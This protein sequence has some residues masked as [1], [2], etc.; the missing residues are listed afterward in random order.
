MNPLRSSPIL[1]SVLLM[2]ISACTQPG[3]VAYTGYDAAPDENPGWEA[4]SPKGWGC[5]SITAA[6][7]LLCNDDDGDVF[8]QG[9]SWTASNKGDVAP[10]LPCD[11]AIICPPLQ[12]A[13]ADHPACAPD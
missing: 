5:T 8:C 6:A 2:L 4:P 11:E 13:T 9:G 12:P 7:D 1:L 3:T 10:I